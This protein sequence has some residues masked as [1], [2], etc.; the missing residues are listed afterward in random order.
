M[1]CV[2]MFFR[3][4]ALYTPESRR[5]NEKRA[6]MLSAYSARYSS[7]IK[8]QKLPDLLCL[9]HINRLELVGVCCMLTIFN[10]SQPKRKSCAQL[11]SIRTIFCAPNWTRFMHNCAQNSFHFVHKNVV[12][13]I[14]FF[15]LTI[16]Y[17]VLCARLC[18][19]NGINFV[20]NCAQLILLGT[21]FKHTICIMVLDSTV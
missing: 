19:Q 18:A 10:F 15:L 4:M 7:L 14:G 5:G 17:T 20:H 11:I 6:C 13:K 16:L 9:S 2:A 1:Y 21:V 8:W 12:H 3:W